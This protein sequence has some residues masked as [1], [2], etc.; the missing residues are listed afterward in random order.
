[1]WT[2]YCEQKCGRKHSPRITQIIIDIIS[3]SLEGKAGKGWT[4]G[5]ARNY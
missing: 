1:M 2:C 3:L 4:D 5:D